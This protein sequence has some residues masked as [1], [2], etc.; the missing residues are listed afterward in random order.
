MSVAALTTAMAVAA[1]TVPNGAPASA[2]SFNSESAASVPGPLEIA[3]EGGSEA[4]LPFMLAQSTA[5]PQS[6]EPAQ[7]TDPASSAPPDPQAP[8]PAAGQKEIVVTGRKASPDDP[9]EELNSESFKVV[10]EVD[11][12]I[13]APLAFAYE[14]IVPRPIR[15]GLRN[16]LHNLGEPVVFVNYLLQLKPGKAAETLGRFVINSTIGVAGVVDVAKRKPFK[17]PHRRNGFA[18]TLGYYGVKPGP[19]F[20]LPLIGPTT[21]RDFIGNRLDLLF[22]PIAIGKQFSRPEYAL[23]IAGLSELNNRIEFDDEIRQMR[24]TRDPYVAARS[25]Y[26]RRRQAEIDALHGRGDG[27]VPVI[28]PAPASS[29]PAPAQNPQPQR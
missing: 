4:S 28:V 25:Y 10:Q 18:N 17:L 29:R 23:P 12:A 20:Y 1:A 19:Y 11:K 24:A 7:S 5:L 26:L 2:A 9:L 13:V 27:T 22:L 16:F 14:D 21:L 8:A 15:K 6:T 3:P